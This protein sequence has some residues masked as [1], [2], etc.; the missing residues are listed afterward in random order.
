M[1]NIWQRGYYEHILRSQQDF[2]EAAGYMA[3]NPVRRME[4]EGFG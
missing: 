2:N 4:K 1:G 3:R